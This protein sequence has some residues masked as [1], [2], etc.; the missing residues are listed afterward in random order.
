MAVFERDADR[1]WVP[2]PE[3]RGPFA[4]LQGGAIAGLLTAEIEQLARQRGFGTAVSAAAWFF[5]PTP[6][7]RL[8]SDVMTVRDGGRVSI[9][10]NTLWPAGDTEACATV[11]VTLVRERAVDL[12]TLHNE[13]ASATVDPL[14]YPVQARRAPHGGAWF[15]DA[16]EARLGDGVVWFRMTMPVV[17]S[18]GPLSTALG[19][20][21]W[22]HGLAR[23]LQNAVADPNPNLTVHLVRPPRGDWLGIRARTQWQ[24]ARGVGMGSGALLDVH[25]EIGAVSMAVALTPFPKSAPAAA[26]V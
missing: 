18:A 21:D 23:P 24:P 12:P 19:P 13:S 3:A 25:G 5:R 8:R 22:T 15:M 7:G 1:L 6:V 4:G 9:I 17:D 2:S 16:M 10:D 11:R 20:A 14:G 26:A